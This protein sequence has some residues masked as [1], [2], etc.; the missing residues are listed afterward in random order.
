MKVLCIVQLCID[1]PKAHRGIKRYC[2]LCID[3]SKGISIKFFFKLTI[4]TTLSDVDLSSSCFAEAALS[5]K[6]TK[7]AITSHLPILI[8]SDWKSRVLLLYS[9]FG[10]MRS[11]KRVLFL[12]FTNL[13]IYSM[14]H[15]FY[16]ISWWRNYESKRD[17]PIL[18][19]KVREG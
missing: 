14:I 9:T 12:R 18:K 4:L 16:K 15:R 10:E 11:L 5:L 19:K 7:F 13:V 17:N 2:L 8:A 1:L 6:R 3:L